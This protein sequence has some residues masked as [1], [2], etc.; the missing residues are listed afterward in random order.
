M[1]LGTWILLLAVI[2][3]V[4]G[5]CILLLAV[6]AMVYVVTEDW[7]MTVLALAVGGFLISLALLA[8]K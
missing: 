5:T 4:M 8:G 6:I 1:M 2:A 3:M 7:A